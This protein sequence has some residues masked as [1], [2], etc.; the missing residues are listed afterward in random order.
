MPTTE[1]SRTQLPKSLVGLAGLACAACCI[2]PLLLAAG[3]LGGAGWATAVDA[4][5]IAAMALAVAA[6]LLWWWNSKRKSHTCST[7]CSCSG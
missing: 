2:L 4:L 7:N 5:P 1:R 3:V 6:G